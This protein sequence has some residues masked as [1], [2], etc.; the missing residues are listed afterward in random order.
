MFGTI[1]KHQTWLWAIIITLTIIS[2]VIFFSPNAKL[3]S[4]RGNIDYGRVNGDP[5]TRAE[6]EQAQRE[7]E[8]RWFFMSG[9]WPTDD[10]SQGY[11]PIRETYQWLFLVQKMDELGINVS[12]ETA[13]QFA[14]QMVRALDRNATP[15]IFA[16]QVLEPRGMRMVDFERYVR[17]YLGIQEL[18]STMGMGGKLVTPQ[19]AKNLYAR[20]RQDLEVEAVFFTATNLLSS[21]TVT[22]EAISAYYTNNLPAYRI[23]ERIQI[24]YVMFGVSNYLAQ[25]EKLITNMTEMVNNYGLQKNVGNAFTNDFPEAKTIDEAKAKFRE[26]MYKGQALIEARRAANAFAGPLFEKEPLNAENLLSMAKEKGLEVKTSAPF[27]R[28]ELPEGLDLGRDFIKAASKLSVTDPFTQPMVT[29]EGVYVIALAKVIPSEVPSLDQVRS[30]VET[31]YKNSQAMTKARLQGQTFHTTLVAALQ[32]GKT[33]AAT[34]MEAGYKPIKLEPFSRGTESVPSA[35]NYIS[36]DQLKQMAYTTEVGKASPF[37]PTQA[38]G[39]LIFVRSKLPINEAKM[40]EEMP[41]FMTFIR[42]QRQQEV[43]NAWFS[44]EA[45]RGLAETPLAR[46]EPTDLKAGKKS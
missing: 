23:P 32:Q 10:R 18:I 36:L 34:A 35:E 19:E 15:T 40:N 24:N 39:A 16:K 13:G 3:N 7:V 28:S 38:G 27:S 41:R 25:A 46:P 12:P 37:Q 20:E 31:D 43:F 1:R 26:A 2:F 42:Q 8:L 30:Q 6:F 11:D 14:Q 17:R 4:A 29:Q 44:E 33:F 9:R 22:P 21:V 45:K 5:V